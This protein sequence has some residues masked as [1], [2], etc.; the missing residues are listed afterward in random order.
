MT[1]ATVFITLGSGNEFGIS[2]S[3]M[4]IRTSEEYGV[5]VDLGPPT[6]E[7]F[8]RLLTNLERLRCHLEE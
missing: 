7:N 5:K 3:S 1:D 2:D 6:R 8:D 4:F